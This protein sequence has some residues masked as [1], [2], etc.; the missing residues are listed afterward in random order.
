MNSRERLA[1]A[2]N[3]Q[4][5]DCIPSDLGGSSMTGISLEAYRNLRRYL[6][7]R[8]GNIRTFNLIQQL[9]VVDQ[10][11]RDR[12]KVD[13]IG[14]KPNPSAVDSA[15]QI[16]DDMPDYTYFYNE[17]G[18]GWKKPKDKGLYYDI[19]HSPLQGDISMA[20][21]DRYPWPNPTDPARFAG[22]RERVRQAAEVEQKGVLMGSLSAGFV[23]MSSW[24]RG[25]ENYL[26]DLIVNRELVEALSDKLLEL[27][28]AYWG[29]MLEECGEYITAIVFSDDL[30][31]QRDLLFSPKAYRTLIKPRHKALF[32]F[33]KARSSARIFFH[34]CGAIRKIIPDLI[35][36]GVDILNPV[37]VS[38]V[39]M[40]T[41]AL[42]R[43]F[44]REL[45]F[46]GGGIDTQNVLGTQ[47]VSA[48]KDEVRRRI[49]DLAAG[50]GFVFATVHSIQANVPPENVAAV[51]ETLHEY[52]IYDKQTA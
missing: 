19:F 1:L 45:T 32:S 41:A 24:L 17:W 13:V 31:S 22:V 7:L 10:D 29:R 4:E 36:A 21:L 44:G 5:A 51:W 11:V 34:C 38:A 42:K 3:H 27:Q 46:W 50:G 40:D 49:D 39:G 47:P 20:D 14:L 52:G 16:K 48:I 15:V 9:A 6:G 26:A 8:E 2:L 35:D 18:I 25:F 30:G 28:M 37:Q 23:E 33:I 43:E 12:F